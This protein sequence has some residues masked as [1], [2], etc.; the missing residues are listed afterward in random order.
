MAKHWDSCLSYCRCPG[1]EWQ[2][3]AAVKVLCLE[4]KYKRKLNWM[5]RLTTKVSFVPWIVSCPIFIIFAFIDFWYGIWRPHVSIFKQPAKLNLIDLLKGLVTHDHPFG[6]KPLKFLLT[7]SLVLTWKLLIWMMENDKD[8][9]MLTTAWSSWHLNMSVNLFNA[10]LS[11]GRQSFAALGSSTFC[12][13]VIS[14]AV[15]GVLQL[16]RMLRSWYICGKFLRWPI[17]PS[18]VL[19]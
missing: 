2:A 11:L 16:L 9:I 8:M 5:L 12:P 1:T 4:L 10:F 15:G 3:H 7:P 13:S 6:K 17:K 18:N 14:S 19:E